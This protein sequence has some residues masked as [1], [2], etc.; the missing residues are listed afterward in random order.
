MNV[1]LAFP[2][3]RGYID[4]FVSDDDLR[5]WEE[6]GLADGAASRHDGLKNARGLADE[7]S[8]AANVIGKITEHVVAF[9]LGI[10]KEQNR[11]E[12]AGPYQV[13]GTEYE[14]GHLLVPPRHLLRTFQ[15]DPV[16]DDQVYILVARRGTQVFRICGWSTKREIMEAPLSD[17]NQPHRPP[18][19][20]LS[21][22]EL[23]S[24]ATL[25]SID[26]MTA[27]IAATLTRQTQHRK[28]GK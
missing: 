6:Q 8:D 15:G 27:S 24:M 5:R 1:T 18:A 17:F 25:P 14:R 4:V 26:A 28:D 7:N 20:V 11:S 22:S 21:Q 19:H 3:D 12:D 10:K 16:P 9:A 2:D 13:K 23:H